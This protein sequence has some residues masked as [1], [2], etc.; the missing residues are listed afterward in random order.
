M[1]CT[2]L[3]EQFQHIQAV[4]G[5]E[6]TLHRGATAPVKKEPSTHYGWCWGRSVGTNCPNAPITATINSTLHAWLF[7]ESMGYSLS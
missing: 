4:A 2:V 1:E 7:T 6:I 5:F 3:L